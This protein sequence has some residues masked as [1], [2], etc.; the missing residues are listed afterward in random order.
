MLL[1]IRYLKSFRSRRA[2][3]KPIEIFVA[4]FVVLAVAIVM[5][6]LFQSQVSEKTS[7]LKTLE[8]Q[9]KV[10]QALESARQ[11]CNGLC[12]D[13]L[14]SGCDLESKAKFCSHR[15]RSELGAA[16]TTFGL[17]LNKDGVIGGFDDSYL[18]GVGI[19]ED[20]VYCPQITSCTCG[21]TLTMK[22]CIQI[23]CQYWDNTGLDPDQTLQN[24]IQPGACYEGQSN[25]WFKLL[26][27]NNTE[28]SCST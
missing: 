10:A 28:L 24:M 13:S 18:A 2:T 27:G 26:L 1:G 19:C 16:R 20:T 9:Q 5:L 23:L 8:Q 22:N 15:I 14:D 17:D 7:N 6:K 4:L 11:E 25:H 3:E 21:I 12:I